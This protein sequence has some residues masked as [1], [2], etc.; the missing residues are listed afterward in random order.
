MSWVVHYVLGPRNG[1]DGP[2]ALMEALHHPLRALTDLVV[3]GEPSSGVCFLTAEGRLADEV[4]DW[5]AEY[6]QALFEHSDPGSAWMQTFAWQ[7]TEQTE[8]K[9]YEAMRSG[10][11]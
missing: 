11:R 7:I 4:Y 3:A 9:V 6:V 1:S 2:P 10:N 8:C 5:G